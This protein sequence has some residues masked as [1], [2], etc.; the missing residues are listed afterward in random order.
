MNI[1]TVTYFCDL[2]QPLQPDSLATAGQFIGDLK[3]ALTDAGYVVQ[4]TRLA[5]PPLSQTLRQGTDLVGLAQALEDASF[6]NR[7]DYATVGPARPADSPALWNAIPDAI[8]ATE[9]VFASG[10]IAD[11]GA[12]HLDAVRLAADVIH[13]CAQLGQD[14]FSNFRF[15]ALANVPSG[16]PFLPAAFH[17]GGPAFVAIGAEAAGLAVQACAE[18]KSLADARAHL[19]QLIEAEAHNISQ[20]V[21]PLCGKRSVGFTGLDFSLAPAPEPLLSI[22]AALERLSGVPAGEHGT[23]AA[24]AFL[25]DTLGRARIHRTGYTGLFLPL[26]EDS[27]LAARAVDGTLTITDLLL[28]SAVCGTGLDTVPLPG[29][30]SVEALSAILLDVAALA[31]RLD[32]P[33]AARLIPI[34]GRAA[35][36]AISFDFAFFAPS[37]VLAPRTSSLGGL[38]AQ[39][40]VFELNPR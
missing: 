7:I 27:V 34:P 23:L 19:I 30:V 25:A 37:R 28:Y 14:G 5:G 40:S 36:D 20:I 31:V 6:V 17:T 3:S 39:A 16:S 12:I 15:G 1:R 32:K 8:A 11:A 2:P 13:R 24:A 21:K 26:L 33:L 35:G 29:D 9:N 38:L 10:L 18:A 22:G 4:T